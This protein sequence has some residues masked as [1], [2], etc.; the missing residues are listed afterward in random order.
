MRSI[1]EHFES[2]FERTYGHRADAKSFELVTV[3]LVLQLPRA[4][5][6]GK[7]WMP[8]GSAT[9]ETERQVYFGPELGRIAAAVLSRR[10]LALKPRRGPALIQ[11][12]DTTIVVPPGCEANLDGH[13]NVVIAVGN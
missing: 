13:K 4:V 8:D 12:Y 6:H 5:E 11:E 1:E 3:R 9:E 2:E 10:A 7:A